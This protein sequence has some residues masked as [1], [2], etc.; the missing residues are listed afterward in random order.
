MKLCLTMDADN[1]PGFMIPV[2]QYP[3]YSAC[4]AEFNAHLISYF[5]NESNNWTLDRAELERAYEESLKHCIP[6]AI[7][8]INPGINLL[9]YSTHKNTTAVAAYYRMC[10]IFGITP[11]IVLFILLWWRCNSTSLRTI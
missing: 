1:K 5:M 10:Y 11:P 7:C 9:E 4:T 6:K 3:L 2:P 8:I